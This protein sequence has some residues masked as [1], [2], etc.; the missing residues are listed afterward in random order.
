MSNEAEKIPPVA[1]G[2][3]NA[4]DRDAAR[5]RQIE[6]QD[7]LEI[8]DAPLA[9]VCEFYAARVEGCGRGNRRRSATGRGLR[10]AAAV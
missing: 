9:Q 5:M 3:E 4:N 8:L 1:G 7:V 2:V 10:I 6:D